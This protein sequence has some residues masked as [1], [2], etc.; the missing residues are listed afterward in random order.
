MLLII[1]IIIYVLIGCVFFGMGIYF[2]EGKEFPKEDKERLAGVIILWP[3]V[4][5]IAIGIIIAENFCDEN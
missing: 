1:G 3:M 5:F 2:S 4:L